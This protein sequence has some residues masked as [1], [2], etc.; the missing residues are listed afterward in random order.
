MWNVGDTLV[1]RPLK[2]YWNVTAHNKPCVI[3]NRVPATGVEVYYWV[4]FE[5]GTIGSGAERHFFSPDGLERI[6][7]KL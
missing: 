3:T 5:D 1:A 7:E 6:L 4:T 2:G